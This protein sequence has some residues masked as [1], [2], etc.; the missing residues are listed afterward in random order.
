MV[1]RKAKPPLLSQIVQRGTTRERSKAPA[2]EVSS[3]HH[4]S[5]AL[6]HVCLPGELKTQYTPAVYAYRA[7]VTRQ[8]LSC[9]EAPNARLHDHAVAATGPHIPQPSGDGI[10]SPLR[11]SCPTEPKCEQNEMAD[12][13][14]KEGINDSNLQNRARN[15]YG[16]RTH[17][18]YCKL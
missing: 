14:L 18:S 5:T 15:I 3:W 7:F 12:V 1:Q 17:R 11:V 9:F 8:S 10:D 13:P 4:L 16:L 6:N 2:V